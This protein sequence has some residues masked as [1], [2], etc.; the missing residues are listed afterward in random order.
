MKAG[1]FL[2]IVT[3]LL[4]CQASE[5]KDTAPASELVIE[6]GLSVEPVL[7]KIDSIQLLYFKNPFGDSIR[8]TRFYTYYNT[9]DTMLIAVLLDE[10]NKS[11]TVFTEDRKCRSNGKMFLYGKGREIKTIYFAIQENDCSYLYYIKNGLF[12]YF[13]INDKTK[14]ILTALKAKTKEP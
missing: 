7:K 10:L 3:L 5:N 12:Y 9:N 2:S 11:F 1:F 13:T 14:K 6:T 8:Y 4:A